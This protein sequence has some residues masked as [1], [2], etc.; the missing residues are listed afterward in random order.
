MDEI[1]TY[2]QDTK[3]CG[4]G[5]GVTWGGRRKPNSV[6]G[7]QCTMFCHLHRQASC[8]WTLTLEHCVE[9]W[10]VFYINDHDVGT[11]HNHDLV[12]SSEEAMAYT[13]MRDIPGALLVTART[14]K[15]AGVRIKDVFAWLKLMAAKDGQEPMFNY[16]DVYHAIGASTQQRLL[17]STN[18]VAGLHSRQQLL[19]LPYFIT[20]DEEG[21]L[22]TAWWA[23]CGAADI[24]A[25]D[26]DHM[27][28][29]FDTKV[30]AHDFAEL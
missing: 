15:D 5:F 27:Q 7:E 17:D 3:L 9:G 13:A 8:K 1:S 4:G 26:P 16:M 22:K 23:M 12:K 28:V 2:A 30:R 18:F 20:L 29:V 10:A 19:G 25:Q 11:P 14:M 21:C 6:R 24:F